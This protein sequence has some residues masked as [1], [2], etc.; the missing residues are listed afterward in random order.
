M[1]NGYERISDI[2]LEDMKRNRKYYNGYGE[3]LAGTYAVKLSTSHDGKNYDTHIVSLDIEMDEETF[4]WGYDWW[5]GE[6]YI[7]VIGYIKIND[8]PD[9]VLK[10]VD[11]R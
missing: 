4:I 5:E 3:S 11:E 9:N 8:I 6:P 10:E 2:L 1:K 7:K